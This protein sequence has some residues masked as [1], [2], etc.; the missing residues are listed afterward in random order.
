MGNNIINMIIPITHKTKGTHNLIIDDEDYDK[1]KNYKWTLTFSSNKYTPYVHSVQ[2]KI[3][4]ILKPS[5]ARP[6]TKKKVYIYDKTI[7]IHRLIMNLKEYKDDKRVINHINGNGLDN[8]KCNLE[9]C[10]IAYNNQSINK[11]HQKFG[12]VHYENDPKRKKKWRYNV[13]IYQK[14]F[15]DRCF[16]KEECFKKLCLLELKEIFRNLLNLKNQNN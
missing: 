5:E 12:S 16:T 11:P 14:T 15:T 2:Y 3:K 8:R 9:I 6:N 10:S 13:R 7:K 4:E 1:I